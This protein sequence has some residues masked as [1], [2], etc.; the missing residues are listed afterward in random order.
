VIT[1]VLEAEA[2]IKVH[3]FYSLSKD[4]LKD[5]GCPWIIKCSGHVSLDDY[6]WQLLAKHV[7]NIERKSHVHHHPGNPLWYHVKVHMSYSLSK[8][9]L[10]DE[11]CPWL[12]KYSG[13]ASLG[14]V[15]HFNIKYSI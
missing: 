13:H 10:R 15:G 3:R 6:V 14:D 7:F 9:A 4:T 8:D 1:T 11:G 12:I 5:E 2:A